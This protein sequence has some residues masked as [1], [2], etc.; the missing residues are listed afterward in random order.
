MYQPY[1]EGNHGE[2]RPSGYRTHPL[3]MRWYAIELENRNVEGCQWSGNAVGTGL[4]EQPSNW[5]V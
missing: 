5:L 4:Y 2:I 3:L 1:T